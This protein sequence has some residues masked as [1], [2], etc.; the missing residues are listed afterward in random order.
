MQ[1]QRE[2]MQKL[3]DGVN[4]AFEFSTGEEAP[5]PY[6]MKRKVLEVSTEEK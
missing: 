4:G 3:A 2:D 1:K 5:T 6:F